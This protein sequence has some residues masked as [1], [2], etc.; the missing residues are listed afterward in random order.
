[1][2]ASVVLPGASP[3]PVLDVD[4]LVRRLLE[5]AAAPQQGS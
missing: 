1:L 3:L 4:A 2:S 5:E